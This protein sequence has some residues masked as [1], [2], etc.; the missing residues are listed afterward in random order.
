M[1]TSRA[2]PGHEWGGSGE[3]VNTVPGGIEAAPYSHAKFSLLSNYHS[4]WAEIFFSL[5]SRISGPSAQL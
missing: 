2:P 1:E 5:H 4:L 3:D